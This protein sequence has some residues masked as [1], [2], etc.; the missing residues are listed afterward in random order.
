MRKA[1]GPTEINCVG[2]IWKSRKQNR[3]LGDH[4]SL[5]Q[6]HFQRPIHPYNPR[7]KTTPEKPLIKRSA[8][9]W[10]Q[11]IERS[12]KQVCTWVNRS[13]L[14]LFNNQ[15]KRSGGRSQSVHQKGHLAL[16]FNENSKVGIRVAQRTTTINLQPDCSY[17]RWPLGFRRR[18][19]VGD[20][21]RARSRPLI[22]LRISHR[23]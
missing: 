11:K 17:R 5:Q 20:D 9:L 12:W 22:S 16:L 2:L 14:A 21:W 10:T 6:S 15:N 23:C 13:F 1:S 4:K 19:A 7:E 8:S 3:A 18:P